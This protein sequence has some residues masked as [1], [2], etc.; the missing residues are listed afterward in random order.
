[1]EVFC[2]GYALRQAVENA[3]EKSCAKPDSAVDRRGGS[4]RKACAQTL[5]KSWTSRV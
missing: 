2:G 5:D 1:M 3:V 4:Q